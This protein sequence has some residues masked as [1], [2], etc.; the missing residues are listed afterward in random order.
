MVESFIRNIIKYTI[1][2][3]K[4]NFTEITEKLFK[5]PVFE[6]NLAQLFMVRVSLHN[7]AFLFF[8]FWEKLNYEA[9]H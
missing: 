3:F 5:V 8:R 1:Y 2:I 7:F 4:K 6:C 9:I